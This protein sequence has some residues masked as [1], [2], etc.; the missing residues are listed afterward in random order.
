MCPLSLIP[1]RTRGTLDR[2]LKKLLLD[3]DDSELQLQW[4]LLK[5]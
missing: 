3:P 5:L 4:Q 2:L 1:V